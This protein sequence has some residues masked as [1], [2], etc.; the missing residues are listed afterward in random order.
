[1]EIKV[2]NQV[3]ITSPSNVAKIFCEILNMESEIDRDKEHLWI[4]GLNTRNKIK[5]IELV[6]LGTL[7]STLVH[8]REVFR[9]AILKGVFAIIM[10]HNHP[11]GDTTPSMEDIEVAKKIVEAGKII[12]IDVLDSIVVNSEGGYDSIREKMPEIFAK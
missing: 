3:E 6:T 2:K 10:V 7:S 11:S 1:M 5:Y 9:F 4:V 12:G 8:P